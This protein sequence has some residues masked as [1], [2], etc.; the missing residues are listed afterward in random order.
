MSEV[1]KNTGGLTGDLSD[2]EKREMTAIAVSAAKAYW[3][4]R[5]TSTGTKALLRKESMVT[6]FILQ[7]GTCASGAAICITH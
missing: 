5:L 3:S 6:K 1:D 2:A 4:V 7:I